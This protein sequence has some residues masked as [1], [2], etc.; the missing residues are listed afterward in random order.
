MVEQCV[1]LLLVDLSLHTLE[2]GLFQVLLGR[3][4]KARMQRRIF[5]RLGPDAETHIGSHEAILHDTV[6][7]SWWHRAF[8]P[9]SRSG[10]IE[11]FR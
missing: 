10:H 11:P 1:F 7:C 4:D 3:A 6:T 9:R 5:E 2:M 8:P